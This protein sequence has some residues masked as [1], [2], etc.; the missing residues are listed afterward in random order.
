MNNS[1]NF[2]SN[3]SNRK[4]AQISASLYSRL[5]GPVQVVKHSCDLFDEYFNHT[6]IVFGSSDMHVPQ[7]LEVPT[8]RNNRYG[9]YMGR[10]PKSV[11]RIIRESDVILIHGFYL[12]STLISIVLAKKKSIYIMPHG[13]L[14]NYQSGKSRV[15]KTVFDLCFRFLNKLREIQFLVGSVEEIK[16]VKSKFKNN[17]VSAVGLGINQV[18]QEYLHSGLTRTPIRLLCMSRISQK[19]RIDLCINAVK[20]LR[21]R[22]LPVVL[23]IA[24]D[25]NSDLV[26]DLVELVD[27]NNLEA[28]VEFTGFVEG[29]N[30]HQ[31]YK[32]SDIFLL[33]SE[34]ENFAV[35]VAESIGHQVPVIVSNQVAMHS[36]V[37]KNNAGIVISQINL[38]E[39]VVAIIDLY[40]DY[41]HYWEGCVDSRNLLDWKIVIS[42][43]VKALNT[44][45]R[46]S[47]I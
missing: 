13:S 30:K 3:S 44:P 47:S 35:A 17:T 33:P 23:T 19:K 31:I 36:F 27:F 12:F 18:P 14:E 2:H 1:I 5:G 29:I 10:L 45:K 26:H 16:G 38:E 9:F 6:L 42:E 21:E 22:N 28:F 34:N 40:A 46:F 41:H 20:V 32:N 24:G 7:H 39:L 15:R 43:W 37:E 8:F 25:G 11:R 4:L